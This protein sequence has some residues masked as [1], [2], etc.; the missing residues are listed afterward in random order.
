MTRSGRLVCAASLVMEMDEVLEARMVSG[1]TE[2]IELLKELLLDL[3]ALA[4]G[5]DDELAGGQRIARERAVNAGQ[6][7]IALGGGEAWISPLRAPY[8]WRWWRDRDPENAAPHPPGLTLN[9]DLAKTWAIPLPMVPAPTTPMV[10][11][12]HRVLPPDADAEAQGK[13]THECIRNPGA[14]RLRTESGEP[15]KKENAP[16][17]LRGMGFVVAIALNFET[18]KL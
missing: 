7:G 5:F 1:G 9:P 3:K 2:L 8:S 16:D 14:I 11:D 6:R 4:G 10:C 17:I 13:R 18:L 12:T 15:R